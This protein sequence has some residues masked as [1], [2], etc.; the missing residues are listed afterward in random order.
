M[1]VTSHYRGDGFF[2]GTFREVT[3]SIQ[4]LSNRFQSI[5]SNLMDLFCDEIFPA[6]MLA[7]SIISLSRELLGSR[8]TCTG[9]E[10]FKRQFVKDYCWSQGLFTNRYAYDLPVSQLPAPGIVPCIRIEDNYQCSPDQAERQ[11]VFHLWYQWVPFY[12]F[13]SVIAFWAVTHVFSAKCRL[14]KMKSHLLEKSLSDDDELH[15]WLRHYMRRRPFTKQEFVLLHPSLYFQ[16]RSVLSCPV[17]YTPVFSTSEECVLSGG[18]N[19]VHNYKV[20]VSYW[21]FLPAWIDQSLVAQYSIPLCFLL[22]RSVFC[23]VALIQFIITKFMFPIGNFYQL[24]LKWHIPETDSYTH[25]GDVLFPKM[26]GCQILKYG[27]SGLGIGHR[28]G[29]WVGVRA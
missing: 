28:A 7:C 24:G 21:E 20:Y 17:Q 15:L 12:F 9:N 27:S 22:R 26:A 14:S 25:V 11:K 5:D 2:T 13:L 19:P 23:L 3:Y 18:P 29:V 8:L 1:G 10:A 4:R 16:D 6:M